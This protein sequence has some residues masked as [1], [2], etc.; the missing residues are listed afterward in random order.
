M[1]SVPRYP[2][3]AAASAATAHQLAP[4]YALPFPHLRGVASEACGAAVKRNSEERAVGVQAV[5][6]ARQQ[7]PADCLPRPVIVLLACLPA[8]AA[9]AAATTWQAR[10]VF[11]L[12]VGFRP[13]QH[14]TARRPA[15]TP[16]IGNSSEAAPAAAAG[17]GRLTVRAAAVPTTPPDGVVWSHNYRDKSSRF[18]RHFHRLAPSAVPISP[19]NRSLPVM[20][21]YQRFS[22]LPVNGRAQ[23]SARARLRRIHH[24]EGPEGKV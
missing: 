18:A 7:R 6:G 24:M 12:I 3:P 8:A 2:F 5:L 21:A 15:A 14:A 10:F 22:V 9:A 13:D 16:P 1:P 4:A 19:L 17:A 11:H 23:P 20:N